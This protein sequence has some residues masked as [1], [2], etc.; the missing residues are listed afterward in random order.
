MEIPKLVERLLNEF[1]AYLVGS[2]AE[3]LYCKWSLEHIKDFDI[4]I[5]PYRWNDFM[6]IVTEYEFLNFKRLGGI[7]L[8]DE[9]HLFDIWSMD[10]GQFYQSLPTKYSGYV[11]CKGNI[12]IKRLDEK[13]S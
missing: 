1:D 5:P 12:F 2:A 13:I 9:G 8:K 4:I 10:L 11:M 7:C 3:Y 6:K